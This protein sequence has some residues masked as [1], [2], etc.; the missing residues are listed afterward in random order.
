MKT[1]TEEQALSQAL[2]T[3]GSIV[4]APILEGR[5][6][7]CPAG[8][9]TR[10]KLLYSFYRNALHRRQLETWSF[11]SH[12]YKY[13][14]WGFHWHYGVL[15]N[16]LDNRRFNPDGKLEVK[17]LRWCVYQIFL[18][19]LLI[20]EEDFA[21]DSNIFGKARFAGTQSKYDCFVKMCYRNYKPYR[22][23]TIRLPKGEQ[24]LQIDLLDIRG[25]AI[26]HKGSNFANDGFYACEIEIENDQFTTF[27]GEIS[28][29][30][31]AGTTYQDCVFRGE[32]YPYHTPI[33]RPA[34]C[35]N[36][37]YLR[38]DP[39]RFFKIIVK[40]VKHSGHDTT[41]E[42]NLPEYEV[43]EFEDDIES[44]F[45]YLDGTAFNYFY[46]Y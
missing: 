33:N 9:D 43:Y 44:V 46:E 2:K 8:Y 45:L 22:V 20:A 17:H 27:V 21:F 12:D 24:L 40:T 34:V 42:I 37:L 6:S 3:L 15:M 1:Y 36:K 13:Y 39:K 23:M 19:G 41:Q 26:V 5:L 38:N 30:T 28:I 7:A 18:D 32:D 31:D 16:Q 10:Q 29:V 25:K 4:L 14:Q 11:C 35:E